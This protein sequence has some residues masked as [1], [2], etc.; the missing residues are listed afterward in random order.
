MAIFTVK[1]RAS[2]QGRHTSGAEKTVDESRLTKTVSA[3]IRRAKEH[4]LGQPDFINLKIE[5]QNPS[6]IVF[7]PALPVTDRRGNSI[8]ETFRIMEEGKNSV[9]RSRNGKLNG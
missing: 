2:Q 7:L 9:F 1:M 3:L 8:E 6:Q 4:E 5:Q